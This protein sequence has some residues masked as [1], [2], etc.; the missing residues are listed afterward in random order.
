MRIK[1]STITLGYFLFLALFFSMLT[2]C[3]RKIAFERSTVV[4]AAEGQ[5]I[6]KR[7]SNKNYSVEVNVTNL[8]QPN[9]LTPPRSVYVV[10]LQTTEYETRNIGQLISSSGL[11]SS[12]L[13][14][15]LKSVS[16]TKPTRVF[17]TAED[18]ANLLVPGPQVVIS[19][20][21][22]E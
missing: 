7:D 9:Q 6:M 3:S 8:A 4:P 2:S 10:W 13:K 19:T 18:N 15:S 1:N 16:A 14:G 12:G 5:V 21:I 11:F 20:P 22:F 17:I